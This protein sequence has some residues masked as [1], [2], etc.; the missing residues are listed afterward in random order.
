MTR[1]KIRDLS[2]LLDAV[3]SKVADGKSSR[4]GKRRTPRRTSRKAE[5]VSVGAI[6]RTIGERAHGPLL[7]TVGLISISPATLAPG[8][9]WALATLT[10]L[11]AVQV[12]LRTPRPWMPREALRLEAPRA[13]LAGFIKAM[14]PAATAV[15]KVVRPRWQFLAEPPWTT[16][17]A[18]LCATAALI[19]FPLGLVPFAPL[20]PGL[21]IVL[22]GLGLTARDGVLLALGAATMGG[23]LLLLLGRLF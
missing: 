20:A 17:V 19:T 23:A 14:R 2:S 13:Q 10:L 11:I 21:A 6:V 7:L 12:A 15:D 18:L 1:S 4:W 3:E 5:T 22:F 9:T 8:A 16:L